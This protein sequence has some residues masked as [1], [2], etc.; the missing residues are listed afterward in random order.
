VK[1]GTVKVIFSQNIEPFICQYSEIENITIDAKTSF[2]KSIDEMI[3]QK[4]LEKM[5]LPFKQMLMI[6]AKVLKKPKD[7]VV[8]IDHYLKKNQLPESLKLTL[9]TWK[10]R[11]LDWDSTD[12]LSND[13]ELKDFIS[14]PP[15]F[16]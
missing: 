13:K 4:D 9:K 12:Y 5:E 2:T 10:K 6:E 3:M 1:L 8:F 16:K 15:F 7:M 11:L 14:K